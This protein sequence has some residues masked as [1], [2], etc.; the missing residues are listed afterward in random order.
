MLLTLGYWKGTN[1]LVSANETLTRT[2]I[3]S[4]AIS[5][6]ANGVDKMHQAMTRLFRLP[7]RFILTSSV[8]TLCSWYTVEVLSM[9]ADGPQFK[10]G[11]LGA[12]DIPVLIGKLDTC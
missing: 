12:T 7:L 5:Q 6:D 11:W 2:A 4:I 8:I 10:P 9:L 1:R 3:S